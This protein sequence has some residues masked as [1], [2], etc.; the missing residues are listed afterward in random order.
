MDNM[1]A[2]DIYIQ[3]LQSAIKHRDSMNLVVLMNLKAYMGNYGDQ[4]V[5]IKLDKGVVY[6]ELSDTLLFNGDSSGYTVS[7]KAK[8]VL[9]RLGRVLNNLPGV[10]FMVEG[11]TDNKPYSRPGGLSDNCYQASLKYS[12]GHQ[13]FVDGLIN[14][15][16]DCQ[17]AIMWGTSL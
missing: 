8:G 7:D 13:L 4:D 17:R 16:Q 12:N 14:H 15:T 1:G 5:N 3:D 2:K 6:V 9:G 11:H 10:E